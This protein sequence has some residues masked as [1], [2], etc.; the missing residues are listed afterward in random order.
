MFNV[1]W[2]K[3]LQFDVVIHIKHFFLFHFFLLM[4]FLSQVNWA[5]AKDHHYLTYHPH[6]SI[7]TGFSLCSFNHSHF[8]YRTFFIYV[9]DISVVG[10]NVSSLSPYS[11]HP[12]PNKLFVSSV[13]VF[14]WWFVFFSF[15]AARL[16]TSAQLVKR[17]PM[18]GKFFSILIDLQSALIFIFYITHF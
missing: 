4:V 10:D 13:C 17:E 8:F 14:S 5:L 18:D 16:S 1:Q 9:S 3:R 12:R 11:V 6:R 2:K 15:H 7:A